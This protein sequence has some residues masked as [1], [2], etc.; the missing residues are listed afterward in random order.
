M[1]SVDGLLLFQASNCN[2]QVPA[3]VYEYMRAK[4][5]ILALT[6]PEGDTARVLRDASLD[7]IVKLDDQQSIVVGLSQFI[8]EIRNGSARTASDEHVRAQSRRVRTEALAA[9]LDEVVRK[10]TTK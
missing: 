3:K 2:H 7:S 4:R 1:F 8:E 5:P 9:L 10:G 6:D